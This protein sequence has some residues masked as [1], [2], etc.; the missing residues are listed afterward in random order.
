[1]KQA[2]WILILLAAAALTAG[3]QIDRQSRY[4]PPAAE[5]VPN[6]LRSFAQYHAASAA[7]ASGDGA[8]ALR[9]SLIH[10]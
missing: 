1:M 6:P 8:A 9:L 7:I 2:L 4:A 5:L 3:A 10:I